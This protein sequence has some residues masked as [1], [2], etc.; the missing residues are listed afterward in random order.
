MD[1]AQLE[2]M[3]VQELRELKQQIEDTVRAA[4]RA[5][6]LAAQEASVTPLSAQAKPAATA[7]AS[8]ATSAAQ[9]ASPLLDLE[10]ERDAWL[11]AKRS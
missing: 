1:D 8:A 4:I 6:R 3:T 9:A 2:M 7:T 5:K 10:R 11:L